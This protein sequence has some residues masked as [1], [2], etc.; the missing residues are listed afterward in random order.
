ME[1]SNATFFSTFLD[2]VKAFQ[3]SLSSSENYDEEQGFQNFLKR[4]V[5]SFKE[6]PIIDGIKVMY[7]ETFLRKER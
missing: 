7:T 2:N 1:L 5:I 6:F 4:F 3:Q